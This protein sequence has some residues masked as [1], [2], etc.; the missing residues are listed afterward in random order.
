M[1]DKRYTDEVRIAVLKQL[2]E[3]GYPV[4]EVTQRSGASTHSL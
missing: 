4:Q 1:Y 2:A 3:H